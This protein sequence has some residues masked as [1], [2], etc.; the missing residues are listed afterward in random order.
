MSSGNAQAGKE[1][2]A[3]RAKYFR[4]AVAWTWLVEADT[5]SDPAMFEHNNL[6]GERD[7]LI[8]VVGNKQD[9]KTVLPP[10]IQDQILHFQT[11]QCVKR[12]KWLV[13]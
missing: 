4:T 7:G 8:D 5:M 2:C 9:S 3:H 6:V 11:G 12:R 13:E 1:F 10:D